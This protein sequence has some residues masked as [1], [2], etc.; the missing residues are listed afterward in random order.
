MPSRIETLSPKLLIGQKMKMSYTENKT[1]ELWS[2]FMTR[3]KEVQN[4][5]GNDLYSIQVYPHNFFNPFIIET[6]FEKWACVEVESLDNTPD[7]ME[8]LTI[9]GGLYAVFIFKGIAADAPA[10]FRN[11]F[12]G[13]LP[14]SEYLLDDRPHFEVLSDKYK[15]DDPASEEEVWLPVKQKKE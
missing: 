7:G 12:T 3:R 14:N 15:R 10:F 1:F 8:A 5:I 6:V 4:S 13:W 9:P 2:S 11:I